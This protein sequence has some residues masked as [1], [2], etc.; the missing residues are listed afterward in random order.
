M[1]Y[2]RLNTRN[3]NALHPNFRGMGSYSVNSTRED[4]GLRPGFRGMG[5]AYTPAHGRMGDAPLTNISFG[6]GGQFAVSTMTTPTGTSIWDQMLTWMGQSTIVGGMP[7]SVFAI[8][9]GVLLLAKV[10]GG[11]R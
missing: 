8:G 2:A 3:V 6:P 11:R 7:N 1:A 10:F 4:A 5:D 9:A